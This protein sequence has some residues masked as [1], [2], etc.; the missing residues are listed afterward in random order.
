MST[1]TRAARAST[2]RQVKERLV[3][4]L[5][6]HKHARKGPQAHRLL[7]YSIY[8]YNDLRKAYLG[9]VQEL[10]PDKQR[11]DP[12]Q[13]YVTEEFQK[14]Q[15]AWDRY[16][17]M[18]KAMNQVQQKEE[19]SPNFTMF[20]VGCSFSDN[21]EEREL[22]TKITDQACR[23]WFSSGELE[24]KSGTVTSQSESWQ[25]TSLVDE[26]MFAEHGR[27][28]SS[29]ATTAAAEDSET[30]S[31]SNVPRSTRKTLIPGIN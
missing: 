4:L 5:F 22:R 11:Q 27:E 30:P 3:K 20:G 29:T 19:D 7:D 2:S 14:L 16:E 24:A 15:G 12:Q 18:A 9:R 31:E 10:H 26:S 17:E 8:S 13:E 1:G 28:D 25:A 23:G 21:D 6:G